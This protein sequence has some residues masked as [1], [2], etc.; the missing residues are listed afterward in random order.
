MNFLIYLVKIKIEIVVL[1]IINTKIEL[2]IL[3]IP[4][5]IS[6][7]K[8]ISFFSLLNLIKFYKSFFK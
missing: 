7:R 8:L 3:S 4:I 1:F 2:N 6:I 5:L